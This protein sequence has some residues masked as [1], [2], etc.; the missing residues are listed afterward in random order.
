MA[1]VQLNYWVYLLVLAA[2]I[3]G[4]FAGYAQVSGLWKKGAERTVLRRGLVLGAILAVFDWV[5][6]N[7]GAL[8][9]YWH[10]AGSTLFLGAVPIE[11]FFIALSAGAA[12]NWIFP[13]KFSWLFAVCS[14][15]VIAV[16][17]AGIEASLAQEGLLVYTGGWTSAH[18]VVAYFAVFLGMYFVNRWL[19]SRK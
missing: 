6:E 12:Y 15:A 11:V 7:A 16:I 9:G 3:A 5:F 2:G 4:S 19:N 17:G 1:L 8:F 10:T 18:A 14:S 13:Q